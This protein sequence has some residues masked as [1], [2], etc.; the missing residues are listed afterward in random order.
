MP[1]SS[2]LRVVYCSA[3]FFADTTVPIVNALAELCHVHLAMAFTR[4]KEKTQGHDEMLSHVSPTVQSFILQRPARMRH[5]A[6]MWYDWLLF[7]FILSVRPHVVVIESVVSPW[8]LWYWILLRANGIP[9]VYAIHDVVPH[10]GSE[11]AVE[12]WLHA[13]R[14]AM[15]TAL[16]VFS[17]HQ[18][19]LLKLRFH[20]ESVALCLPF[21]EYLSALGRS[22][23][24]A[25]EP[26]TILLFGTLRVN[27]G[28]DLF[29][30]A[31]EI[32]HEQIP[33]LKVII[34][35]E[36]GEWDRFQSMRSTPSMYEQ[37]LHRIPEGEMAALF[38]RAQCVVLP[39]RD[40][41]QSGIPPLAYGF[42]C[43]VIATAVGGVSEYVVAGV[44]GSL[45]PPNDP[46]A[47]ADAIM[48]FLS[49][50]SLRMKMQHSVC[51][52]AR[53]TFSPATIAETLYELLQRVARA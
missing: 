42:D 34:A 47:L 17:R 11:H 16:V 4:T 1:S 26:N 9:I 41:T 20:R 46:Q 49:D 48:R 28:I 5:P 6:H 15:A 8:F 12:S 37:H 50:D 52:F 21:K 18:Q 31:V 25:R 10:S 14:I 35:G 30:Q 27:K 7:R 2:R 33:T 45:V 22:H 29:L 51:E 44:T 39:Y 19:A 23:T 53:R 24:V 13:R 3:E 40:A 38:R 43:P 32:V 36:R